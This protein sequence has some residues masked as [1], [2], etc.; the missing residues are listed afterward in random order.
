MAEWGGKG[1]RIMIRL[2]GS[3]R[4]YNAYI[5]E[6]RHAGLNSGAYHAGLNSGAYRHFRSFHFEE[7]NAEEPGGN[8]NLNISVISINYAK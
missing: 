7:L 1:L 8:H 2:T 5:N 6:S 3:V 4:A